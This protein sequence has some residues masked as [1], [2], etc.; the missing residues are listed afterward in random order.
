MLFKSLDEQKTVK[1]FLNRNNL[2]VHNLVNKTDLSSFLNDLRV[3]QTEL[4]RLGG[5]NDGGYLLPNDL[6]GI[7]ACFSPGVDNKV[8]FEKDLVQHKIPSFMLDYS[9][10]KLPEEN[11]FFN[12]DRKYLSISNNDK[13][14]NFNSWITKYFKREQSCEFILQMDIEGSEYET[15]LSLEDILIKK[16]RIMVIEFHSFHNIIHPASFRQIKATF[17]KL[18]EYFYIVH[19][20]PNNIFPKISVMDINIPP[21]LEFTF[22]RKDRLIEKKLIKKLPHALDQKNVSYKADVF[23]DEYW[24]K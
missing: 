10:E 7:T 11:D 22:L 14:I 23:L 19:I 9:I 5:N 12:F 8:K 24:Y 6:E 15:L 4:V 18:L 13:N 20:H 17:E 3:Y 21:L 1:G 16:F 2:F